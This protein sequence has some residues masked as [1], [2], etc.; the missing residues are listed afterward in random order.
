MLSQDDGREAKRELNGLGRIVQRHDLSNVLRLDLLQRPAR[1][2]TLIDWRVQIRAARRQ[3]N[4]FL[5][6]FCTRGLY[7]VSAIVLVS[8]WIF[9]ALQRF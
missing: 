7:E 8:F 9:H 3:L 5:L 1:C 2:H 4:F 6:R